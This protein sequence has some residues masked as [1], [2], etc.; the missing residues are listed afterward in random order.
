MRL[1]CFLTLRR[2][3]DE[4]FSTT[5]YDLKNHCVS[6]D[7]DNFLKVFLTM[8]LEDPSDISVDSGQLLD[9]CLAASRDV[10]NQEELMEEIDR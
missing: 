7:V 5:A 4:S 2:R 1:S 6:C 3:S 9:D 10:C 8:V